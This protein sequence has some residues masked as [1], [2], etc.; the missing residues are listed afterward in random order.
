MNEKLIDEWIGY[1]ASYT[2]QTQ[3]D[4]ILV[5]SHL[6]HAPMSGCRYTDAAERVFR[7]RNQT[8]LKY[9]ARLDELKANPLYAYPALYKAIVGEGVPA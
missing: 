3:T 2:Q 8:A 7:L 5:V 1:A 9:L 4:I 6:A